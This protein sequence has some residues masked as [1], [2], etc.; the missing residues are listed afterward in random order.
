MAAPT[1]SKM[2]M[3]MA[4]R[5]YHG[6]ALVCPAVVSTLGLLESRASENARSI[7]TRRPGSRLGHA[8][9]SLARLAPR[10]AHGLDG[11]PHRRR[12][13]RDGRWLRAHARRRRP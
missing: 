3:C 6:M 10:G 5:I 7:H 8:S 1:A 12:V 13:L 9:V 4:A 11:E 2:R